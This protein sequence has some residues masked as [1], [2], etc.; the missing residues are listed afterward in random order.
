MK[1]QPLVTVSL[2]FLLLFQTAV[3]AKPDE[4]VK[5]LSVRSN[6]TFS[7]GALLSAC[8]GSL[9]TLASVMGYI[10][11]HYEPSFH[12]DTS[13]WVSRGMEQ[14]LPLLV[15]G[16]S[17]FLLWQIGR[18]ISVLPRANWHQ[19]KLAKLVR[20]MPE[21]LIRPFVRDGKVQVGDILEAMATYS[22]DRDP[23]HRS[24][25]LIAY[26]RANKSEQEKW[27]NHL[28]GIRNALGDSV[29]SILNKDLVGGIFYGSRSMPGWILP[30]YLEIV[31]E[32]IWAIRL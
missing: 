32:A 27:L 19:W 12:R 3:Q 13:P 30:A 31:Q 20:Q 24:A 16:G 17:A 25:P 2:A 22:R 11:A 8:G 7:G 26:L 6:P 15:V 18:E 9:L 4:A 5:V 23:Y 21:E 14:G 10:A 1:T 28:Y 29:E